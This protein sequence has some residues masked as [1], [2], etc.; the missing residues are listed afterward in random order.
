LRVDGKGRVRHKNSGCS[1]PMVSSIH[2]RTGG[3]RIVRENVKVPYKRCIALPLLLLRALFADSL[4]PTPLR[5]L[6]AESDLRG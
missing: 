4:M 2:V 6:L 5:H 1:T 3:R